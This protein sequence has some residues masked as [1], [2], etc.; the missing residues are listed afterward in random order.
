MPAEW[1]KLWSQVCMKSYHREDLVESCIQMLP[2]IQID[3][4]F[5]FFALIVVV[6]DLMAADN[7]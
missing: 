4:A 1:K 6:R 2:K 5:Y 7:K 3:G